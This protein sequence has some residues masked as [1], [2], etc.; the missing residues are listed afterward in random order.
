MKT[1]GYL[2][3]T[4]FLVIIF[5]FFVLSVFPFIWNSRYHLWNWRTVDKASCLRNLPE[6]V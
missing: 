5:S 2:S 6:K 1:S 3:V 4:E